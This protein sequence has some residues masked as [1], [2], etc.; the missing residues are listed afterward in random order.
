MKA[1]LKKM[2]LFDDPDYV[3]HDRIAPLFA[4]LRKHFGGRPCS[5]E[6]RWFGGTDDG[7]V[8]IRSEIDLWGTKTEIAK[9][10]ALRND[11]GNEPL[12]NLD[13]SKLVLADDIPKELRT[14]HEMRLNNLQFA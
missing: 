11:P 14:K 7:L 12:S 9:W 6:I 4:S 10:H 3:S 5:A 1:A 8:D 2:A 13:I